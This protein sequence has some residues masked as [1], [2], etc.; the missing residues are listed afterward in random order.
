MRLGRH[1]HPNHDRDVA[2]VSSPELRE[3]VV[4]ARDQLAKIRTFLLIAVPW[5]L[6]DIK[7]L[8]AVA[9]LSFARHRPIGAVAT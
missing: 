1:Q 6:C 7:E 8:L 4:D 2:N 3:V 9:A 5:S